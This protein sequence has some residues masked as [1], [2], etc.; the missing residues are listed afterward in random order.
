MREGNGH[1]GVFAQGGTDKTV[2]QVAHAGKAGEG[3]ALLD[4]FNPGEGAL[5]LSWVSL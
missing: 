5:V 3:S 4:K 1:Q 2:G